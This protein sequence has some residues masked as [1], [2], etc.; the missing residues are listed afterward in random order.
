MTPLCALVLAA[1]TTVS[2]VVYDDANANGRRDPGEKGMA[3]V[4]ISDGGGVVITGPDGAY[5]IASSGRNVFVMTPGDR[6]S[7]SPWYRPV[8]PTIDFGLAPSPVPGEWR[9]A[10]LSDT[11]VDARNVDRMRRALALAQTR[12]PEF[13]I[14]TG[15]LNRDALRVD[16]AT[17]RARIDLYASEAA[18][19]PMPVRSAPGNHDIFGIE[20]HLSLVPKTN[21]VYGKVLYE[22]TLGPRYYSF[23]RGRIH[24]VVLDTLGIDDLWYYGLLEDDEL[25]W[26]RKDLQHVPPGTT[27]VTAGHVPFKTGHFS[28]EYVMEGPARTMMTAK[29]VTFYRH[30]V[31]NVPALAEILKPYR[32]TLALQGHMHVGE[33]LRPLDGGI[34]RFHTAPAV[35]REAGEVRPSGLFI[36]TVRGEEIDDGELLILEDR[37]K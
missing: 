24:F 30:I 16:E 28:E 23:N 29:G 1:V 4:V 17:A 36:Y 12:K 9:F 22:Q 14:V 26:L 10:H 3:G 15:D 31:R 6:R 21:P 13:A 33:R 25:A 19:A 18:R 8:S 35:H 7:T 34:T 5:A 37:Q 32:W 11:H 20:R 27:V 2:G